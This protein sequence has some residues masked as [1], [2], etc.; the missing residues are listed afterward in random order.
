MKNKNEQAHFIF[1]SLLRKNE[2]RLRL[3]NK[4]EQAHFI[5]HSAC[6]I[7]APSKSVL[8]GLEYLRYLFLFAVWHILRLVGLQNMLAKDSI[9]WTR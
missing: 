3:G 2:D 1:L 5:F 6:T 8:C 9:Y 4:N 7:F